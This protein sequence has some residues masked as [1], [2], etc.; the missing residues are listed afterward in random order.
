[1]QSRK[2]NSTKGTRILRRPRRPAEPI[3]TKP[4]VKA[5]ISLLPYDS[6]IEIRPID[7]AYLLD[8][9]TRVEGPVHLRVATR[10][11]AEAVGAT[12]TPKSILA[13]KRAVDFAKVRISSDILYPPNY[14][15]GPVR[16]YSTA[17]T[18]DGKLSYVPPY[19]IE[20]AIMEVLRHSFM[21]EEEDALTHAL[22]LLGFKRRTKN[23]KA[24]MRQALASM[25]HRG[26]VASED[27]V[28]SIPD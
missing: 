8:H 3:K 13:V 1:M 20:E 26:R 10:R 28:V 25:I 18:S 15:P 5:E 22:H 16:D 19:E 11:I 9:I 21:I 24:T 7:I 2:G 27:G 14:R 4:Y 12:A 6:V 23:A 17:P